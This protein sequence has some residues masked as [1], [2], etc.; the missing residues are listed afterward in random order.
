MKGT[1]RHEALDGFY[2]RFFPFV[3]CNFSLAQ[4]LVLAREKALCRPR[5]TLQMLQNSDVSASL[6]YSKEN[7]LWF[8][9]KCFKTHLNILSQVPCIEQRLRDPRQLLLP[10]HQGHAFFEIWSAN[11]S[12]VWNPTLSVEVWSLC[13]RIEFDLVS[14]QIKQIKFD[15]FAQERAWA[16]V[17]RRYLREI[18]YW[19]PLGGKES[20]DTVIRSLYS[21]E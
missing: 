3:R 13:K 17:F 19:P 1:L 5:V 18:A 9:C 6:V 10:P 15:S 4:K 20:N 11:G 7:Q 14:N 8:L 21:K 2:E 16:V 12:I